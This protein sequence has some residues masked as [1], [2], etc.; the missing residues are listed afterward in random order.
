MFG[1]VTADLRRLNPEQ[2]KRYNGV[3]CGICRRIREQASGLSRMVLS[4]DMAF[5]AL[6][7]MSLYEPEEQQGKRACNLHPICPRPWVDS[8]YIRYAADM[9]V[10][11]A[12][13]KALDDWRTCVKRRSS[14]RRWRGRKCMRRCRRSGS[15]IPG[16]AGPWRTVLN[17]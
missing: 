16:S 12:Y 6:L 11:L 7:L 1:Y 5:L 3:Y 10:A 17:G 14:A 4:Y 13:Y 8:E 15:G 2:R 9:N